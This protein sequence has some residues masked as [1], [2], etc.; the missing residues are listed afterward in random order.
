MIPGVAV[1]MICFGENHNLMFTD[2]QLSYTSVNIKLWL[3]IIDFIQ[4]LYEINDLVY[5]AL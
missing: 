3:H 4:L 1:D 2:V 5:D